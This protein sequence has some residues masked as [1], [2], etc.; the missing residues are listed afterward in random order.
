LTSDLEP[1]YP[2]GPFTIGVGGVVI[3][4]DKVLLVKLTYGTKGWILPGGYVKSTETIGR[5]IRREVYEETG[6]EVQPTQ[7]VSVRSRVNQGKCDIY[8]AFLVSVLGGQI[9]ADGEEVSDVRYFALTE[10][11]AR[12]DVPKIN[13]WIVRRALQVS[14]PRFSL[15]DYNQNPDQLYELWF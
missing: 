13:T 10:M 1:K 5:A 15:S 14:G 8:V 6:L 9:R 12:E 7:I 2:T 3:E 4:D 11:E